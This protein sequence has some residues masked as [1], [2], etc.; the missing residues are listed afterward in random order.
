MHLP[1]PLQKASEWLRHQPTL[2]RWALKCVPDVRVKILIEPIGGFNI[3]LRR[4]RSFWLRHPLTHELFPLGALQRLVKPDSVVYDVGA[5]IGLYARFMLQQFG[6]RCVVCFEPMT[7]NRAMLEDNIRAGECSRQV[8]I[9]PW[10]LCDKEGEEDL[11]VDDM[12]SGSATLDRVAGGTPA[13]GRRQYGMKALTEKVSVARLDQLVATHR[14]PPPDVV[15]VD[16]E[17]AEGL[18]L[19]GA[20][21]TL[22]VHQPD[23]LVEL[24]GAAVAGSV[25]NTLR[26]LGYACFGELNV[27]GKQQYTRITRKM[28]DGLKDYYDL[29]FI[30][31]SMDP[32]KLLQPIDPYRRISTPTFQP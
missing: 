10:A 20:R 21:E 24:H 2:G 4:N 5:N 19:A 17:G 25:F 22:H 3:R 30:V 16:I 7:E 8:Q 28:I 14:L 6:A 1:P 32:A 9:M 12:M 27:D 26:D 18:M 29:H 13:N 31:A 15:K 23:L 11:Q